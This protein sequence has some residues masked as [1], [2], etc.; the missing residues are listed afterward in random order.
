M[1]D[2]RP[3]ARFA[4]FVVLGLLASGCAADRAQRAAPP[5]SVTIVRRERLAPL[6][7]CARPPAGRYGYAWPVRP[8]HRQHPIRG[9]FGDP[10]TVSME[11]FGIDGPGLSGDYSF[12]NGVDISAKVGAP[13]YPVVSG[14]A[15]LRSGDEVTVHAGSRVFQYWH[16]AP[17]VWEDE[18]VVAGV[19]ILGRVR[20]PAQHVHLSEIDHERVINPALHLRPYRDRTAPIV[21]ALEFRDD[22]GRLLP[23]DALSGTVSIVAWVDD[24]PPLSAPGAWQGLPVAPASVRWKLVDANGAARVARIV[25]DFRRGEPPRQR[26][27]SVY[28]PGTYQNFPV[29]D[30]HFYWHQAGRFLFQLTP[31][32]FDTRRLANG[33]YTLQVNASDM[34]GN[35]GTLTQEVL[36][37]NPQP[38]ATAMPSRTLSHR[39][40][41]LSPHA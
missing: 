26:F 24:S 37:T 5:A 22:R 30:N 41:H 12:H 28:A 13:V 36:I 11:E 7:R 34:C 29:F 27:W 4:A 3:V 25:A 23:A 8:F 40:G 35:R 6:S 21:H 32:R 9:N 20:Y 18:H 10:R 31:R 16:I 1:R 15:H 2:D 38:A 39:A 33:A 17:R 19:T 14:I